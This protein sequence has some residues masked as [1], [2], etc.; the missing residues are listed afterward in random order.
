MSLAVKPLRTRKLHSDSLV[1][2]LF[3]RPTR[4]HTTMHWSGKGVTTSKK[5]LWASVTRFPRYDMRRFSHCVIL[6]ALSVCESSEHAE[7]V[8]RWPWDD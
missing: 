6:F 4:K 7:S 2:I 5:A 1:I 8:H 3:F